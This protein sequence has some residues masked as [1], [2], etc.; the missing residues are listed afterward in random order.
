MWV[1]EKGKN[2]VNLNHILRIVRI[3]NKEEEKHGIRFDPP[4]EGW[5]KWWYETE[6]DRDSSLEQIMKSVN[7]IEIEPDILNI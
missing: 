4:G 3:S 7:A 2:P 5:T 1:Y 6:K